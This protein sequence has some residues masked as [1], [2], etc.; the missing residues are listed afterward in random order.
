[1]KRSLGWL[2]E[3]GEQTHYQIE[4]G[5]GGGRRCAFWRAEG[6]LWEGGGRVG[7]KAEGTRIGAGE[8]RKLKKSG[9]R[10]GLSIRG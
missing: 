1:M 6:G 8:E 10:G 2:E 7:W 4:R 9:R 5:G 3:Q